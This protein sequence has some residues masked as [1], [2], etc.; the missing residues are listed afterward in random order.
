MGNSVPSPWGRGLGREKG[1]FASPQKSFDFFVWNWSVS[2]HFDTIYIVS[3]WI[4]FWGGGEHVPPVPLP[5]ATPANKTIFP[6]YSWRFG[7]CVQSADLLRVMVAAA[8]SASAAAVERSYR[9][10]SC[11]VKPD[12]CLRLYSAPQSWQMCS[13]QSTPGRAVPS[14]HH[15]PITHADLLTHLLTYLLVVVH[16]SP[17][18]TK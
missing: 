13:L 4:G 3:N 16:G 10:V 8:P 1:L 17:G 2:V 7:R 12:W 11:A 18:R 14:L 5:V 6:A 15:T 9:R